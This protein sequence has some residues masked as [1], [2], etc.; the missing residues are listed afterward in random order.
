MARSLVL[1]KKAR[2]YKNF[3]YSS[4]MYSS[5][6]AEMVKLA[7]T[8]ALGAGGSNIPWRFESS[9]RHIYFKIKDM[10][11][12]IIKPFQEVL[13]ERKLCVGCTHPLDKAKKLGNLS[14]NRFMVECKCRRRYV[15]DKE[16]G[17]YQ[18]AT[19]AEEQQM[20]RDLSKRG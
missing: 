2:H 15:Y 19:F 3:L 9:S 12:S 6:N 17:S 8:P 7:D 18:R 20:L 16:M 4:R 1:L 14:S 11:K 10:I 5:F 13:L